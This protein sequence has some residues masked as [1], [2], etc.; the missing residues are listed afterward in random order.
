MA[1]WQV[2]LVVMMAVGVAVIIFGALWD[3]ERAV[4]DLDH[5]TRPPDRFIPGYAESAP[6][7]YI[8]ETR[9]RDTPSLELTEA[10]RGQLAASM[11]SVAPI[12][13]GMATSEFVSD[14]PTGWAV[15][16]APW[17]LAC[18]AQVGTLHELLQ[19]LGR[20]IATQSGLVVVTPG[21]AA[22]VQETLVVNH[23]HRTMRVLV[24]LADGEQLD[25][26]ARRCGATPLSRTDLQAGWIPDDAL[27]SAGA[28]VSSRTRSWVLPTSIS[29]TG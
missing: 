17:V 1:A 4:R 16:D 27:G 25:E 26:L 19:P 8:T 2:G 9:P 15:V 7:A 24:V 13:A 6:P 18:A 12:A 23:H 10:R 3:R 11:D 20:A 5:L 21:L 28:W 29:S 14:P 22:E